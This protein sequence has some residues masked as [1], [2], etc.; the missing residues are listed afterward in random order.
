[1]ITYYYGDTLNVLCTLTKQSDGTAYAVSLSATVKG[2]LR[3]EYPDGTATLVAGPW[4]C[5]SGAT[6]A[7]W[8]GGLVIVPMLIAHD[9]TVT[10]GRYMLELEI[11][12]SG[13][14]TTVVPGAE[15][16]IKQGTIA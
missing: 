3:K 2:S 4:T 15:V 6:G 7:N 14:D 11:D 5:S 16:F 12:L 13:V 10:P 9:S 8:S 1:M